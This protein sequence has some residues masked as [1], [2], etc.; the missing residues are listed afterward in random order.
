MKTQVRGHTG[1]LTNYVISF[2]SESKK[3]S[4][5]KPHVTLF[6]CLSTCDQLAQRTKAESIK[7][8]SKRSFFHLTQ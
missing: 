6:D 5:P 4:L 3:R 1:L 8:Q 7:T 2:I